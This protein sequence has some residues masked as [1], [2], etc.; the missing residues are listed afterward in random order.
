MLVEN[1]QSHHFHKL[2]EDIKNIREKQTEFLKQPE[3][4]ELA[5]LIDMVIDVENNLN[6]INTFLIGLEDLNTI[7]NY[8]QRILNILNGIN[9]NFN[10]QPSVEEI[11]KYLLVITSIICKYPTLNKKN[12]SNDFSQIATSFK[13]DASTFKE[14]MQNELDAYKKAS[15]IALEESNKNKDYLNNLVGDIKDFSSK[16]TTKEKAKYYSEISNDSE[17]KAVRFLKYTNI[18]MFSALAFILLPILLPILTNIFTGSWH[19][20]FPSDILNLSFGGA[21]LRIS[22]SFLS[23]L[24]ALFFA[25]FEKIYRERAFKFKDLSNA[26]LSINPYL[27]DIESNNSGNYDEKEKFKIEMA[28]IFFTQIYSNEKHNDKDLIKKLEQIANI[29]KGIK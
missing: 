23:L 11:R 25:Q 6:K 29:V 13:Q 4:L 1:F 14:N 5:F 18:S 27:A 7:T 2:I 10:L 12:I 15:Q 19:E 17:E 24:P 22:I 16:Y 3:G 26:I 20:I 8:L 21:L 28:K 9:I